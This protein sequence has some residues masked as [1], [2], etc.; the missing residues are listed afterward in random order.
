[1]LELYFEVHMHKTDALGPR[2][3]VEDWTLLSSGHFITCKFVSRKRCLEDS[4]YTVPQ[5]EGS[6]FWEATISA[7]LSK[8]VYMY[9]CPIPTG[10]RDK[11]FHYTEHCTL[12][13]RATR[14]VLT[15]VAKCIDVDG[16]IFD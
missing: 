11:R 12:Y 2:I 13:R 6:T 16:G 8:K 7:I 14:H 4:V 9:V 10:F 5:E 3:Q 1:M 15:R